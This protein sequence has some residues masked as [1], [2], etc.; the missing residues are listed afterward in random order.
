MALNPFFLNGSQTEQG[1]LQDLINEQIKMYGVDVHYLPRQFLRTD[2]VE[3]IQSEFNNAYPLEAYINTYDGFGGQQTLLTKFGI[4]EKD[5]LTITISKERWE[6][7]IAPLIKNQP[8]MELSTRP[9][10]GDLIYFPLGD[11]L[12]EIKY[13]EH[14]QPFYMLRENYVYELRCELFRYE[15]E[16]IDTNIY[17]IDNELEEIGYIQTLRMVGLGSTATAVTTVCPSGAVNQIYITNMGGSYEAQPVIGFSSAPD[18]GTTAVGVAS[19]TNIYTNCN[20]EYGGKVAYINLTNPGC[21]YT[22]PPWITI[23]G[24][25]GTGAAATA[26]ICTTGSVGIVTITSGGSGYTTNPVMHFLQPTGVTSAV[27]YG[28]INALGIVT[29]AYITNAGCGYE[30]P[31]TITFDAPTGIGET[32]GIGTYVFNEVVTGQTSG[33]TAYVKT[34]TAATSTLTVSI[35]GGEFTDGELLYGEESGAIYILRKQIVDDLVTPYAQNDTL[36]TE[37]DKVLDFSEDNPFGMP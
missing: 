21:G 5:D 3:V 36:Q 18:G 25:G 1:L 4:E 15:D 12:F 24:G 17:E 2:I 30:D 8:F 27:G 35:V 7:Y 22:E 11:R 16:V 37:A 9:R 33:I 23:R 10:E 13:V 34:W 31:P 6:N 14:E 19:L 20:G 29:V 26:G 32:I 28:E